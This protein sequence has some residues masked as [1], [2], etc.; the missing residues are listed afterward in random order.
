[1]SVDPLMNNG[2]RI[3]PTK[4]YE[5]LDRKYNEELP[6]ETDDRVTQK[7]SDQLE[8]SMEARKL[9]PIIAK[10]NEGFYDKPEIMKE[11]ALRIS[12]SFPPDKKS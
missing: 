8:I 5:A 6:K 7:R 3:Y 11:T 10:V 9:S 1:M 4:P 12:K 2:Q